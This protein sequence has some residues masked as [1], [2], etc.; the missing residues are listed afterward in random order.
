M[1]TKTS[2]QAER[3][4]VKV[5]CLRNCPAA[6]RHGPSV[7]SQPRWT[8]RGVAASHR[9]HPGFALGHGPGHTT[10]PVPLVNRCQARNVLCTVTAFTGYRRSA[11]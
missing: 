3:T 5:L 11:A 9:S 7:G 8:A 1:Q 10:S 2:F 4:G 6:S